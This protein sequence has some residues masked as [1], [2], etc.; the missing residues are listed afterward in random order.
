MVFCCATGWLMVS[1]S[2]V[3]AFV[4]NNHLSSY[5]AESISPKAL[6]VSA[7]TEFLLQEEEEGENVPAVSIDAMDQT[8][9]NIANN[10]KTKL[11]RSE[12]KSI[13]RSR[14]AVR[15]KNTGGGNRKNSSNNNNDND[16]S[17]RKEDAKNYKLHSQAVS[18]LTSEST[19]DDVMRAIKRAQNLQDEE[20]IRTIENFLLKEVDE[21]FA[22]GYRG[23]LLSRLA[24]AALHMNNHE[25]ARKAIDVRQIEHRKAMLP[26]ESAAIIRGLLRVHNVTDALAILEDEL[27][28]PLMVCTL[29]F[30]SFLE[31]VMVLLL[32]HTRCDHRYRARR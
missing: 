22:F 27:S 14:K 23:S 1:S 11:S 30:F 31:L 9:N 15:G 17:K 16:D 32:T 18:V 29:Y 8:K 20:D 6:D 19:A 24:V 12:R 10:E 5:F 4:P 28:L 21:H 2:N 13:E 3:Q 25:L 7:A 26:L